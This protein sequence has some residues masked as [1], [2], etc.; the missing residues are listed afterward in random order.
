MI[1]KRVG[2]RPNNYPERRLAG[3][4]LFLARTAKEGLTETLRRLW[5]E[6]LTPIRR[7]KTFEELFPQP[8][9]FWASHCSWTGK[10]LARPVSPLGRGRVHSIIGNVFVPAALARARRERDRLAEERIF[11]FF[12]ALPRE[13]ENRVVKTMLP[14]FF[15]DVKPPN[16]DFRT[17]QGLLQVYQDWC[18]P[19][20]S[21]RNC[22]I[23]PF[24]DLSYGRPTSKSP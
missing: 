9:G 7:R 14:R 18:E 2:V 10:K 15:S 22:S 1:W 11:E 6:D 23:I 8:I 21:C 13:P 3:A 20:P 12:A 17:Q 16:M 24:L 4:A 19:N 5:Q